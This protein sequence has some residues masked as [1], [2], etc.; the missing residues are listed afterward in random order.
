M[1]S[2]F[3]FGLPG[4]TAMYLV[5]YALTL[6]LHV[7]FMSYVL[8]GSGYLAV[9]AVRRLAGAGDP[10][11]PVARTLRDWL[12]FGLGVAITAGVAPLLFVQILYKEHFYTANLL[13]FHRWMAIVPVLMTG[14]YLLYLSKAK[15]DQWSGRARAA[16]SVGAF[17]CF[18]FIAFSFADNH[19]LAMA[20]PVR[21]RALYAQG[22]LLSVDGQ[23]PFRLGV[24]LCGAVPVFATIIGWQLRTAEHRVQPIAYLALGGIVGAVG[25]AALYYNGLVP[26]QRDHVTGAFAKPYAVALAVGLVCQ[27]VA[28]VWQLRLGRL[29]K[30]PL[31]LASVGAVLAIFGTVVVREAL[32]LGSFDTQQL[33]GLHER[34]AEAGGMPLFVLF[35]VVNVAVIVW[36]FAMTRRGL[37]HDT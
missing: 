4:A 6:A 34:A 32:R 14:F 2:A 36:C 15:G 5:L 33:F 28:W 20:G 1:N 26:L 16:V 22:A 21:W 13:L 29:S 8:A 31:I 30:S 11:D 18:V 19:M 12:P 10:D 24:W 23:T 25:F 3:P 27:L 37:S 35:G 9:W 7:V 17:G